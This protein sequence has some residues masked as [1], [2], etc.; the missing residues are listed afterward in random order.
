[1]CAF[2]V[3][4]S[5]GQRD[6]LFHPGALIRAVEILV[7]P[8]P[9]VN[10]RSDVEHLVGWSVEQ[11]DPGPSR[12]TLGENPFAALRRWHVRQIGPQ[13]GVAVYTL[14]ADP[15]DQRVQDFY[16]GPRVVEGPVGRFV[17]DSEQARQRCQSHAG[18]LFA[19][20]YPAGQLDSA[21]RLRPGPPDAALIGG[22]PQESHVEPGVVGHQHRAAGELQ[23]HRQHPGNGRRIA[24]HGRGD[25][26][27]L[28]DLRRNTALRVDQGGEL[29]QH[30][31]ASDLHRAYLGDGVSGLAVP[32][33][34]PSAGGLEVDNDESRFAQGYFGS[35]IQIGEAQLLRTGRAHVGDVNQSHRH[36]PDSAAA[37]RPRVARKIARPRAASTKKTCRCPR[38]ASR[39]R[40]TNKTERG[41]QMALSSEPGWAASPAPASTEPVVI[42]C[43][44]CAVR[45]PGCRD[46]VVSVILGVPE[47]LLEDERAAL[48]VLADAGMAPRLRLVPIHR[49]RPGVA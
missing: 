47:T 23:K 41:S 6:H 29:T 4:D 45:G 14:V 16:G 1:V 30:H 31:A 40:S 28:N 42:D 13:F 37:R 46:C 10:C 15:F 5:A 20:E 2:D 27:Q 24:H 19:A 49:Q 3:L 39:T 9:Q 18:R 22:S 32:A 44:D 38:L 7:Y 35:P 25:A 48:E 43:E 21:Q 36:D 34:H 26:G 33:V 8:A 11:V 12:Q 17:G